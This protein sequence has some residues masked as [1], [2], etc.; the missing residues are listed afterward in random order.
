MSRE[1]YA[2]TFYTIEVPTRRLRIRGGP[3]LVGDLRI[4]LTVTDPTD[5]QVT[6]N[7]TVFPGLPAGRFSVDVPAVPLRPIT[8]ET[9]DGV[10][11]D[12][13][14]VLGR[15]V[16]PLPELK[17][18]PSRYQRNYYQHSDGW[19]AEIL[20]REDRQL[21]RDGRWM[22]GDPDIH[23]DDWWQQ[24][25]FRNWAPVWRITRAVEISQGAFQSRLNDHYRPRAAPRPDEDDD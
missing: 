6:A 11:L 10:W 18:Q 17:L 5:S 20:E 13:V 24:D 1:Q 23:S 2:A 16:T 12:W 3:N 7:E 19:V 22:H 4:N 21:G 9:G 8:I 15:G 25:I 14:H